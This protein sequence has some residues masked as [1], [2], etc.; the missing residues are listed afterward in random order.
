MPLQVPGR[1]GRA[2]RRGQL[3]QTQGGLASQQPLLRLGPWLCALVDFRHMG[4]HLSIFP[5]VGSSWPQ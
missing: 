2:G 4:T 5:A 3:P 1:W